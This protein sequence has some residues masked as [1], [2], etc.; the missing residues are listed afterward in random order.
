MAQPA[1][2]VAAAVMIIEDASWP[3]DSLTEKVRDTGISGLGSQGGK[4]HR[5]TLEKVLGHDYPHLF[6]RSSRGHYEIP[7]SKIPVLLAQ[8][9]VAYALGRLLRP[10]F[11][12]Y[13]L[14]HW[15]FLRSR[16]GDTDDVDETASLKRIEE[17]ET[18]FKRVRTT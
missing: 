3:I 12:E 14:L 7:D 18:I 6:N 17:L 15:K 13:R 16:S 4:T 1:W 9:E 11:E 10:L 5:N 8:P 2:A